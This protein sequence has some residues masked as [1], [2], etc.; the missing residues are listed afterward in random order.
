[1]KTLSV[2]KQEDILEIL[3]TSAKVAKAEKLQRIILNHLV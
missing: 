2:K 3:K 1:M